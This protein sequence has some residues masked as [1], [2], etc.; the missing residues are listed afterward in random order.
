M[1]EN[2]DFRGGKESALTLGVRMAACAALLALAGPPT[3]AAERDRSEFLALLHD[4]RFDAARRAASRPGS[5]GR[6]DDAFFNAFTTYWRLVFDDANDGLKATL[7]TELDAAVA[8]AE[9][10]AGGPDADDRALWGGSSHLLIAELRASERRPLAAAFEA[11]KAKRLLESAAAGG[12]D[13]LFGLGTYNYV[14]DIVPSY[15][16]GLRALLFLP[17]GDRTLG[18]TQLATAAATSRSFALEARLFLVTIYSSKHE[19]LYGRAI[20]ER[21]SLVAA[22]PDAIASSYASAR[23][24]LGLGRNDASLAQL[25]AAEERAVS[26]GDVDPVVLRSLELLRARAE[27]ASLRPDLAAATSARA[28]A[29]GLGLGPSIQK[30]LGDV[31]AAAS[32]EAEGIAWPPIPIREAGQDAA[33]FAALA[34]AH[35]DHPILAL[36]AGDAHLRAGSAETAIDWFDRASASGLPSDLEGSYEFRRGQAEDLLGRRTQ[37]VESYRRAASTPGFVARD[38]A[39]YHQDSPYRVAP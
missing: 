2:I 31:H 8:A 21:N 14:A 7:D 17:K 11:K 23:L 25:R 32:R 16:K 20:E 27:L 19:R 39:S 24:D 10:A 35:P 29:T 33:V 12:P 28:L 38:G 9:R 34:E 13:A 3:A 5:A 37:A 22:F 6:P 1:S 30:Q 4:G 36:L 26:L 15:V 18:L